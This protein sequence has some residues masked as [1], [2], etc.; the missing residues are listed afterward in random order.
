MLHGLLS[1]WCCI[2]EPEISRHFS[3]VPESVCHAAYER[4]CRCSWASLAI[5]NDLLDESF[6]L[7]G[8]AVVKGWWFDNLATCQPNERL[9]TQEAARQIEVHFVWQS[10]SKDLVQVRGDVR[11]G[12]MVGMVIR[13]SVG[14]RRGDDERKWYDSPF[15]REDQ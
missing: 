14:R 10:V 7:G 15:G 6:V 12:R 4:K 8:F 9:R 5:R 3:V 11:C 2:F 13:L 1:M